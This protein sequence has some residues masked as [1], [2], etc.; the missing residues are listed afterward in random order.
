MRNF[1]DKVVETFK[2]RIFLNN[3]FSKIVS[4][5]IIWKNIVEPCRPHMAHVH[6][7]TNTH[8]EYV[9]LIFHF[10]NGFVKTPQCYFIRTLPVLFI[11]RF[12]ELYPVTIQ[13]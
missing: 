11:C 10:N 12:K 1:S 8:S 3:F 9:I 2:T 5:Q 13:N 6:V 4:Y 7:S